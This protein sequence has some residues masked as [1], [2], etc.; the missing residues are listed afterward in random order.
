M[1][2][3]YITIVVL[4]LTLPGFAQQ[5]TLA[6]LSKPYQ[7]AMGMLN[8]LHQSMPQDSL[9][10]AEEWQ[11]LHTN[12]KRL[13]DSLQQHAQPNKA[14]HFETQ[15]LIDGINYRKNDTQLNDQLEALYSYAAQHQNTLVEDDRQLQKIA[16]CVVG[17]RPE[18]VTNETQ[19]IQHNARHI[20]DF[21]KHLDTSDWSEKMH[22]RFISFFAAQYINIGSVRKTEK[23]YRHFDSLFVPQ[24]P[25]A[26]IS[27]FSLP[28]S[29]RFQNGTLA[30]TPQNWS[31]L[32]KDKIVVPL[33]GQN[34]FDYVY[35]VSLLRTVHRNY[36]EKYDVIL[37][38]S[39]YE[40]HHAYLTN[41][42]RNLAFDEYYIATLSA[43]EVNTASTLPAVF[44]VNAK[45]EVTYQAGHTNTLFKTL[46]AP[47]EEAKALA[48]EERLAD[49]EQKKAALKQ[50]AI[51]A[52]DSISYRATHEKIRFTLKG[53]WEE[54]LSTQ[55][56]PVQ[57]NENDSL[58][59]T[60]YPYMATFEVMHPQYKVYELLVL[61]TGKKQDITI[62]SGDRYK[63]TVT[64][65]KEKNA[66]VHEA[67][68]NIDTS[69]T[70]QATYA[71]LIDNYPFKE[72]EF[73]DYLAKQA[74]A[75]KT[76]EQKTINNVKN[77]SELL[78]C[79]AD[80]KREQMRQMR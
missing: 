32:T 31:T 42:K 23:L 73:F 18:G 70:Q 44:I 55:L 74:E 3:I 78:Q 60:S 43:D 72:T 26:A 21:Y 9:A 16:Q 58:P 41:V 6:Q 66:R 13:A 1:K 39:T 36:A 56:T 50:H 46:N 37:L 5:D 12:Y 65:A 29:L 28:D 10:I 79:Y 68:Q 38:R 54:D 80:T 71:H 59:D 22:R 34:M 63:K 69:L 30:L 52:K 11:R 67:I 48:E 8:R 45:N 4:L 17:I 27:N 25:T 14:I 47:V 76:R 64:Y 35:L 40:E 15:R 2:I 24:K 49:L 53:L 7:T 75:A 77:A 51:R 33:A 57:W 20:Q 62:T 19:I 61:V